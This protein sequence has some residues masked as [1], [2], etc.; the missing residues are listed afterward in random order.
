MGHNNWIKV[1]KHTP[2]KPEIRHMAR[3]CHVSQGDAFLAWFRLW[4]TF[5]EIAAANG[6]VDLYTQEDADQDAALPGA[7][8]ALEAAG[9]LVWDDTGVTIVNW[10]RHNGNSA[11]ERAQKT[12]RQT[13]WRHRVDGG[14]S[15]GVDGSASTGVDGATSTRQDKSR[16]RPHPTF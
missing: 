3:A 6:R 15:T 10:D 16:T 5:D 14:A 11:K 12:D 7:A 4:A 8:K 13:R 9:W 2:T 1:Q